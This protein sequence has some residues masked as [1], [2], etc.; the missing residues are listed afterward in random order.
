MS[1]A[2]KSL[3][4]RGLVRAVDNVPQDKTLKD[5]FHDFYTFFGRE[6]EARFLVPVEDPD[7]AADTA[8]G[9]R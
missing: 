5:P 8:A 7:A 1:A 4:R 9:A 2:P 3:A 6:L